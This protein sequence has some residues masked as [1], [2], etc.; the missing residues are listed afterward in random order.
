MFQKKMIARNLSPVCS[1][2]LAYA[3][4]APEPEHVSHSHSRYRMRTCDLSKQRRD[5][6]CI[7]TNNTNA[8]RAKFH[9]LLKYLRRI[10]ILRDGSFPESRLHM[11]RRA[12][13]QLTE[14]VDDEMK[15]KTGNEKRARTRSYI[16]SFARA[17]AMDS[18][19]D[20]QV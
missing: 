7:H 4:A 1:L 19:A 15:R 10:E 14:L 13:N 18:S 17:V 6:N 9:F 5:T 2:S 12:M 8:N 11:K 20:I 16:S 3:M